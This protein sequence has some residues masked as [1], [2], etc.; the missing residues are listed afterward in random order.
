MTTQKHWS[1]NNNRRGKGKS[2]ICRERLC[3]CVFISVLISLLDLY[4][5]YGSLINLMNVFS[6]IVAHDPQS[7]L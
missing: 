2:I 6:S 1:N 7:C 4:K 3:F 5:N